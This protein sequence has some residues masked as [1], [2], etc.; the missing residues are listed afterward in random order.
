MPRF[1]NTLEVLRRAGF[2]YPDGLARYRIVPSSLVSVYQKPS[3]CRND[4]MIEILLNSNYQLPYI[5]QHSP[6]KKIIDQDHGHN[7]RRSSN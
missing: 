6:Y 1:L 2:Q 4:E 5:P 3:F 7:T